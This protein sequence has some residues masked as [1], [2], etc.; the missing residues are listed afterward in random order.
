MM[1]LIFIFTIFKLILL[2]TKGATFFKEMN[3]LCDAFVSKKIDLLIEYHPLFS[4]GQTPP[5]KKGNG[6]K[7]NVP[8]NSDIKDPDM[9]KKPTTA[10]ILYF[11][12]RK[13]K[14]LAEYPTYGI[15]DITK[16]IAKEWG[17]LTKDQ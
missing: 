6:H 13:E 9:P 11:K 15:T 14:F 17:E 2:A 1:S 10:Y 5:K 3:E 16:L 8:K 12:E 4:I 7:S